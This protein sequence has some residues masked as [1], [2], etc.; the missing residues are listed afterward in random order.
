[1]NRE[2]VKEIAEEIKTNR[3]AIS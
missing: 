2:R 1:M 3:I